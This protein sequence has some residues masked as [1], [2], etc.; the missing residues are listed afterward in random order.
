MKQCIWLRFVT[1]K[2]IFQAFTYCQFLG[3]IMAQQWKT[4]IVVFVARLSFLSCPNNSFSIMT[5]S[6]LGYNVYDNK[7]RH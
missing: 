5:S 2:R 4:S 6:H 3:F 7:G 1:H